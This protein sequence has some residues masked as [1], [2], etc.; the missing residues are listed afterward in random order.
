VITITPSV[1]LINK[2]KHMYTQNK[3]HVVNVH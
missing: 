2:L 1:F 3:I